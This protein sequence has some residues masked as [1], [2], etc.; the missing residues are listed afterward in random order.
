MDSQEN[1]KQ[2]SFKN[3]EFLVGYAFMIIAGSIVSAFKLMDTTKDTRVVIGLVF[4]GIIS[5]G[6]TKYILHLRSSSNTHTY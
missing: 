6:I 1:N 4:I 3:V 2:N 5:S